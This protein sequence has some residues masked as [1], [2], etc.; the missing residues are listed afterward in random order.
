MANFWTQ[1][2]TEPKRNFRFKVQFTGIS[3]TIQAPTDIIWWAKT[4][5]TPSFEVSEVEHNY[6]DN[7]FYY[8]GRVSWNEVSLTLVD[9]ISVDAVNLTNQLLVA[10]GYV[11][12][13]NET[14]SQTMSKAQAIQAGLSNIIIEVLS[15]KG[16]VVE[17]WTL[18]NPFIKSAKYGD[19]DYS[20]DDLRT[21]EMSIRYD[22]AECINQDGDT[23]FAPSTG[24]P[25][26]GP[27]T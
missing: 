22:W 7:K 6:L 14:V 25:V 1:G 12:K 16:D 24:A 27:S 21:V 18:N 5:T 26:I 11:V 4:V 13:G 9:P 2:Q 20:S 3:T 23:L 10:S 19:L 15:A 8:P 17:T